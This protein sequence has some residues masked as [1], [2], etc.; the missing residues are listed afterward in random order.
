M[1]AAAD[2]MRLTARIPTLSSLHRDIW[3]FWQTLTLPSGWLPNTSVMFVCCMVS[4]PRFT[5]LAAAVF[6]AMIAAV[7][8]HSLIASRG[9]AVRT[10][11][12]SAP[13][14][15]VR[16]YISNVLRNIVEFAGLLH[17]RAA[18]SDS[19]MATLLL[20]PISAVT[21]T[22][23]NILEFSDANDDHFHPSHWDCEKIHPLVGLQF[24]PKRRSRDQTSIR[25]SACAIG[26]FPVP[27]TACHE[28]TAEQSNNATMACDEAVY[29][30]TGCGLSLGSLSALSESAASPSHTSSPSSVDSISGSITAQYPSCTLAASVVADQGMQGVARQEPR[31]HGRPVRP[32]KTPLVVQAFILV[33]LACLVEVHSAPRMVTECTGD[34][35]TGTVRGLDFTPSSYA[36]ASLD[37]C[38]QMCLMDWGCTLYAF[39]NGTCALP[40]QSV[41]YLKYATEKGTAFPLLAGS[42][43]CACYGTATGPLQPFPC[44]S[45]SA[46]NCL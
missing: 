8:A 33:L 2:D 28:L 34:P 15:V 29:G 23:Q 40:G 5:P 43:S 14:L 45:Y 9:A 18:R 10:V 27:I 24:S 37:A 42:S 3:R 12:E 30:P 21:G 44:T 19:Q 32:H 26:V 20:R 31:I 25:E 36:V 6:T 4:W 39:A 41:C 35:T 46:L 7:T 1:G 11:R 22:Q 17:A 13:W 38:K 16:D